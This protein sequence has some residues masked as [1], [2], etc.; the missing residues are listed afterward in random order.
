[1]PSLINKFIRQ[2]KNSSWDSVFLKNLDTKYMEGEVERAPYSKSELVY[3]CI[4]TTARAIGQIPI[5]I[6][7]PSSRGITNAGFSRLKRTCTMDMMKSESLLLKGELEPVSADNPYQMLID[8][9]NAY[10]NSQQFKEALVGFTLLDGNAWI[11]PMP[12]TSGSY[13]P[14]SL[15]ILKNG[16]MEPFVNEETGHLDYWT[17]VA[18]Q[19]KDKAK[20][21]VTIYPDEVMHMKLWNPYDPILGLSPLS[22]AQVA[23]RTDFKASIYNE[24]FFDNGAIPEGILTTNQRLGDKQFQ[25]AADQFKDKHQ[26]YQKAR[27]LAVLEQGL[28]WESTG[29]TQRDMEFLDLRKYNRDTILQ[30]LGMKPSVIGITE[31]I[32]YST[33]KEAKKEWWQDTNIPLMKMITSAINFGLLK[34]TPYIARW[35]ISGI[36]ALQEDYLGK[37]EMAQKLWQIGFTSNE[38]NERFELGFEPKPWRDFAYAPLAQTI[39]NPNPSMISPEEAPEEPEEPEL[40]EEP[41]D[42]DDDAEDMDDDTEESPKFILSE[43]EKREREVQERKHQALMKSLAVYERRFE[44]KASKVFFNMRRKALSRLS[45]N[46]KAIEDVEFYEFEDERQYVAEDTENLY[47]EILIFA[48]ASIADDVGGTLWDINS[49]VGQAF[50]ANKKIQIQGIVNTVQKNLRKEIQKGIAASESPEKIVERIKGL[51]NIST[52]RAKLIAQTQVMSVVN[53]GR[54]QQINAS[55]YPAREWLTMMD[56]VVRDT[57]VPMHGSVQINGVP[58]VVNGASMMYPGDPNAPA[59][60]VINCRCIEIPTNK[61][62]NV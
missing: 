21:G 40:E 53:F 34:N 26:G 33:A 3:I 43:V 48:L 55:Q 17:Y 45:Q 29:L 36:E 16:N 9:P 5:Q 56:S 39:V 13:T 38:L 50:L 18:S 27:K 2:F 44:S 58:W 1:M 22:P 51:F 52:A 49:P 37:V 6:L 47:K 19:A 28:K 14:D 61:M 10:M 35:D 60:E 23:M 54:S 15:W 32:N 8:Y 7:Q 46:S 11:L 31:F 12:F 30:C 57:H 4:S 41:E 42:M 20:S 62:P 25:R 59:S 24:K